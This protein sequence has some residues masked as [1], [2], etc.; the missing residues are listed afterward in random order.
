MKRDRL[1]NLILIL[2]L[3]I[4]LFTPA[5]FHL[6][7]FVNRLVK[8]NPSEIRADERERLLSYNWSL[9]DSQGK[10]F[11]F[12][13]ARGEVVIINFWASWCPPCVAEMPD[14]NELYKDYSDKVVFLF[15]ARDKRSSIEKFMNSKEYEFPVFY[16]QGKAPEQLESESMPTTYILDRNGTIAVKKTGAAAWNS[17]AT[18]E[19]LNKLLSQEKL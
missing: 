14:L 8:F 1:V 9:Q 6:K 10:R 12:E 15:V 3:A 4:V 17:K 19:L 7:V 5:G 16:D 13:N 2:I 11:N 18:R